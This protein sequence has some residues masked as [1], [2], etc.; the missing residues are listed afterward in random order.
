MNKRG[1]STL[2]VTILVIS[3]SIIAI[4]IIWQVISGILSSSKEDA[5]FNNLRLNMRISSVFI[6]TSYVSLKVSRLTGVG[7]IEGLKFVFYDGVRS[8][9]I[10]NLTS[11]EELE[12]RTF[13]FVL[14]DLQYSELKKVSVAP[15]IALSSGKTRVGNVLDTYTIKSGNYNQTGNT[16]GDQ[17]CSELNPCPADSEGSSECNTTTGNISSYWTVFD[18]VFGECISDEVLRLAEICPNECY[19]QNATCIAPPSCSQPS[20]CGVDYQ[21]GPSFCENVSGDI[22]VEYV[23]YSCS[24]GFCSNQINQQ[25]IVDCEDRGCFT[26]LGG[27][28]CNPGLECVGDEDC[29]PDSFIIG[30]ER[31]VGNEVWIERKDNFCSSNNCTNNITLVLKE[32]GNCSAKAGNWSCL[33]GWCIENVECTLDAHC[34]PGGT[35]GKMCVNRTC[36]T[37]YFNNSGIV[38]SIWPPNLGE[39]FDSPNLPTSGISYVNYFV[40]NVLG[41]CF[42]VREHV[43]PSSPGANS[44]LRLDVANTSIQSEDTY[45]V[46]KTKLN[47]ECPTP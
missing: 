33:G 38:S 14:T 40:K 20:D 47:C 24:L 17:I 39:Y 29:D 10:E 4:G 23:N 35:C 19:V 16:G 13:R 21:L 25:R 46:W 34:N 28:E 43:Y 11:L 5:D 7:D 18:C 31:C 27:A 44:Y 26:G 37:E 1:L 15:I 6:G 42:R 3:L 9:S 32:G 41:R 30:S 2:V 8:E 36:V 45:Q 12:E 22:Y